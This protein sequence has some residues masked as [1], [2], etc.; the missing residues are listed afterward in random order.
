MRCR[1]SIVTKMPSQ[2]LKSMHPA[3]DGQLL[4]RKSHPRASILHYKL[5]SLSHI[6]TYHLNR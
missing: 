2:D 5:V 1:W 3:R 6:G 4:L